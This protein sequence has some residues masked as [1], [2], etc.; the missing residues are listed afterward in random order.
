MI[1]LVDLKEVVFF[2]EGP[3]VRKWQFRNE[4]IKLLNVKNIVN[5]ELDLSNTE[6]YLDPKE[7]SS[8]YNHFLLEPNDIVMASS[9]IT[10]GKTAIVKKEHLPLCL[11]TSTIRFKSLDENILNRDYLFYFLNSRQFRDQIERLITGSAQPNFGPSHLMQVKLYLP[12]LPDQKRIAAILDKADAV[13]RKR[14]ETIQLLDE[15]LRSVFL[16]MFGDPVRNE[17]CFPIVRI[18]DISSHVSSGSTPLGGKSTYL[19]TGVLFIR[20]QNVHMNKLSYDDIAYISEDVHKSM[21]RSWVKNGD[22]LLN[23]T[24]ASIGR[25][26]YYTG[27][28]DTANVNQHVCIIRPIRDK[29]FPEYLSFFISQPT[30]QDLILSKNSGAT[31]QAFTFEQ[32]KKFNI[33]LPPISLQREFANIVEKTNQHKHL[34]EKS[35]AGMEESFNCIIQKAFRGEL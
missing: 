32:I 15:F 8:S 22:V 19:S 28:D 31:R 26:A 4:G 18:D 27:D 25:V 2:Q 17:K 30:Y 10:W 1:N 35:L 16:E 3:G 23:I 9:G 12:P 7:V 13:R 29:I 33:F 6:R 14:Q 24:G 5:G 21:Q 34:L 11:N 20:S